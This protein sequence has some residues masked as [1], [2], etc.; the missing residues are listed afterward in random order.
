MSQSGQVLDTK[1]AFTRLHA[2]QEVIT[3]G[4][5]SIRLDQVKWVGYNV[6]HRYTRGMFGIGQR[7]FDG[8]WRFQVGNEYRGKRPVAA[9]SVQW[10]SMKEHYQP[11]EWLF[12]V[13]LSRRYLEP[14]L[15]ADL[16]A[17]VRGGETVDVGGLKVHQGGIAGGKPHVSLPW[18]S[19][20][21]TR[22]YGGLVWIYQAGVAKP[23]LRM[24]QQNPNAVL[25]P[26]LLDAVRT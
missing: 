8:T 22:L 2:D 24:P 3:Y 13:N 25:I 26:A 21:G 1:V 15:I 12:L 19:L 10:S 14:R 17:R 9:I 16:V 5:E 18:H 4:R 7:Y 11:E 20:A 23:L 6:I